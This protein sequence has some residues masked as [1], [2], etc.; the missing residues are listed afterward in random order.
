MLVASTFTAYHATALSKSCC[1]QVKVEQTDKQL[2]EMHESKSKGQ[3]AKQKHQV[4]I[5]FF[6]VWKPGLIRLPLVRLLV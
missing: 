5:T 3:K 6:H 1:L 2:Q 4:P